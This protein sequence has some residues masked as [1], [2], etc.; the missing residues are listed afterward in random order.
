MKYRA[1]GLNFFSDMEIPEFLPLEFTDPDVE[2][3]AG[4]V[5]ER[6]VRVAG[7]EGWLYLHVK[8]VARFLIENGNRITY[9]L[10]PGVHLDSFRLFLLG[11]AMGALLLQRGLI[12]LHGN[13]ISTDGETCTIFVGHS[14]A[15]KSTTAAWYFQNGA[16]I[17]ADDV[18][19]IDFDEVGRPIVFPS[20]PQLK[21]WQASADLLEIDTQSLRRVRPQDNKFAIR[22]LDQFS[23]KPLVLS[24][25]V[26]LHV[27]ER[28]STVYSGLFK[29]DLLRKHTYR[30]S[31]LKYL[32]LEQG[33]CRKLMTLAGKINLESSDRSFVR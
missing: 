31:F 25:V 21:L 19:A 26:E 7:G 18:C 3:C 33:Y 5:I 14:G 8:S 23:A 2:I 17:L 12:V 24:R 6:D 11:S 28:E 30:V 9:D 10:Y 13:A 27:E 20:Y 32:L 15:G 16:T 4:S 29:L 1:F 22:I